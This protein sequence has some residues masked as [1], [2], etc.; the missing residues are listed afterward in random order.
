MRREGNVWLATGR[1]ADL[2]ALTKPPEQSYTLAANARTSPVLFRSTFGDHH[3]GPRW[4]LAPTVVFQN[5]TPSRAAGF[6][7]TKLPFIDFIVRPI[8][9]KF[10]VVCLIVLKI[11]I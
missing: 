9:F 4:Q 1:L 8:I 6:H 11:V 5:K 10:F 2:R 7:S 3:F